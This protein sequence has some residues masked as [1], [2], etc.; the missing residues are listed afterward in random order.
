MARLRAETNNLDPGPNMVLSIQKRT[1]SGK[2][3]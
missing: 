1:F 3:L 2:I